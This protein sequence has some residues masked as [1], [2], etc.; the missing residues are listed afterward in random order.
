MCWVDA[1]QSVTC[2]CAAFSQ[3]MNNA[4]SREHHSKHG[5]MQIHQAALVI[6]QGKVANVAQ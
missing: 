3:S 5:L 1:W 6:H 4:V 2:C